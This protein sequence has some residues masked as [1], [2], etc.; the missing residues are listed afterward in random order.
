MKI[1][2]PTANVAQF[3]KTQNKRIILLSKGEKKL[4][5]CGK[6]Q[7]FVVSK[8]SNRKRFE[9]AVGSQPFPDIRLIYVFGV[10]LFGVFETRTVV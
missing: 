1:N 10:V 4:R 6:N 9:K 5:K 3:L 8:K 2:I 7:F